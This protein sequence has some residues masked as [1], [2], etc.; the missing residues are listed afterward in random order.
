MEI[1]ISSVPEY[2]QSIQSPNYSIFRGQT[3]SDWGLIPSI[4]RFVDVISHSLNHPVY[5]HIAHSLLA[6][7]MEQHHL[8][9]SEKFDN[10][11]HVMSLAQHHGL[12][13]QLLD[14]TSNPLVA[15]FFACDTKEKFRDFFI[16]EDFEDGAVWQIMYLHKHINRE[17]N[18]IKDINDCDIVFLPKTNKRVFNQRGLFTFHH[19]PVEFEDG[20]FKPLN[21][22]EK[23]PDEIVELKKIIINKK[24]KKNILYELSNL[25]IDYSFI[26]PDLEGLALSVKRDQVFNTNRLIYEFKDKLINSD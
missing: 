7:F 22:R 11:L 20:G 1:E 21:E 5:I 6:R 26:Y 18:N 24:Y 16:N 12:P 10:T 17:Y 4:V 2:I 9:S 15:L 19:L 25:G 14:W 13:T 8:F 3:N 23:L